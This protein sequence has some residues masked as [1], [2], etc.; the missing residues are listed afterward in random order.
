MYMPYRMWR[1]TYFFKV[2]GGGVPGMVTGTALDT[3]TGV[4]LIIQTHPIF[5]GIFLHNGG[6]IT[7]IN[8]GKDTGGNVEQY[9]IRNCNA[10]GMAGKKTD[11]GKNRD[12]VCRDGTNVP[13]RNTGMT[14]AK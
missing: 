6:I 13:P 12:G 3:M 4:G 5:T 8:G 7:E 14:D 10:T 2:V 11:D 9:L 1:K